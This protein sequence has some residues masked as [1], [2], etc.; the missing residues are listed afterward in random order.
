MKKRSKR[1]RQAQTLIDSSKTYDLKEAISVLRKIPSIKFDES[2][3]MHLKLNIDSKKTGQTIRGTVTLPH[4]T[5]KKVRIIVF[6]KGQEQEAKEAG[7][8]FIGGTDLIEKVGSGFLDFDCAVATPDMMKELAKLGKILGPRGLMPSPKAGTVTTNVGK[9]IKEL[10]SGKIEFRIDKQSDIHVS[11][12]RASFDETKLFENAR[13]CI[14]AIQATRPPQVKGQ[15]I[16]SVSISRT[17]SP[18]LRL[19]I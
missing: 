15:F 8:D 9:I 19:V 11:I 17:M 12:G 1:H 7:A 14:D 13:A 3:D 6:C 18:G 5:G 10:K 4:G 16:G 2:V